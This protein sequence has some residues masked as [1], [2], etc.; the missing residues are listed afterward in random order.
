MINNKLYIYKKP[1]KEKNSTQRGKKWKN[2][3]KKSR[4][5]P[6]SP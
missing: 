6:K 4:T 5:K 3:C 2:T 1:K